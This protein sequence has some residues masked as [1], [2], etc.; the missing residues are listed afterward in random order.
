MHINNMDDLDILSLK[1]LVSLYENKSATFVAKTLDIPA[2]KISRSLKNLREIFGDE[3]FI[4]RTYGLFPNEFASYLYPIAKET[5]TCAAKFQ[6]AQATKTSQT[7]THIE[8]A[9]PGFIAHAFPKA[10]M[11]AIKE[12]QKQIEIN[13]TPWSKHTMQDIISGE[14]TLGICCNRVGNGIAENADKLQTTPLQRI[15]KVYLIA[16]KNHPIFKQEITLESIAQYPFINTNLGNS[17]TRP[18]PYQ[19][20]CAQNGINL[21][22]EI[23]LSSISSLFEYLSESQTIS[24]LPYRVIHELASDI[25]ELHT[26]QLSQLETERL[27]S[28]VEAPTIL[29]IQKNQ[30]KPM[31]DDLVWVSQQIKKIIENII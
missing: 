3:L 8:I 5:I 30:L 17:S 7:K 18:S 22:T 31:S 14:T 6:R 13:V 11:Q 15:N 28:H 1:I 23:T 25:P 21:H 10:L 26:C 27:H 12:E 20:F 4:R 2:P 16:S 9:A 19:E 29:L 24:L